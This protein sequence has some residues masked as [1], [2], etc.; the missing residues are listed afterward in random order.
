M[1]NDQLQ[2]WALIAEIVGGLAV[3]VTLIFLVVETRNNTNAIH[4]Q[5]YQDLT[6]ELNSVRRDIAQIP[7]TV[8]KRRTEGVESLPFEELYVL[9][10]IEQ[11]IWGVYESAYYAWQRNILGDTEWGR[12]SRAI[13]RN[14]DRDSDMWIND[15]NPML[16]DIRRNITPEF[17][18]YVEAQ[19]A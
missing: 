19:C 17:A 12:F 3:V 16:G 2:K 7:N 5:T 1:K 10:T 11:S 6:S 13:C 15:W 8:Q 14:F 9:L 4:T 18:E